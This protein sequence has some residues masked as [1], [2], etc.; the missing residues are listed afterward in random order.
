MNANRYIGLVR[1]GALHVLAA[2]GTAAGTYRLTAGDSE[3]EALDLTLYEGMAVLVRGIA[4]EGWIQSAS[5][6]EQG[7]ELLTA[8]VARVF[9][10]PEG[11]PP[12]PLP[13]SL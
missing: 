1:N 8:V 5:V 10:L 11:G 13:D 2:S 9:A 7:G 6:V 3:D 4:A 12:H